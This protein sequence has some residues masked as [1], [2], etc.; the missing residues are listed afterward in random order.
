MHGR[1][2]TTHSS[3]KATGDYHPRPAPRGT[4]PLR[5]AEWEQTALFFLHLPLPRTWWETVWLPTAI[6]DVGCWV[7]HQTRTQS[8][9]DW[10]LARQT[11]EPAVLPEAWP[12]LQHTMFSQPPQQILFM[13]LCFHLSLIQSSLS[14]VSILNHTASIFANLFILRPQTG[15]LLESLNSVLLYEP[16]TTQPSPWVVVVYFSA[17]TKILNFLCQQTITKPDLLLSTCFFLVC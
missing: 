5:W 10:L 6:S 16:T 1:H 11:S 13:H 17:R 7:S 2:L 12:S 15:I 3:Q 14:V 9:E 8:T 4:V